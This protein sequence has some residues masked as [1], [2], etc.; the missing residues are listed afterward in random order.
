MDLAGF[1]YEI[2]PSNF[3][4]KTDPS[5]SLE[6]QSI[7]LAYGKAKDVFDNTQGDRCIIGADTLVILDNEQLGKPIS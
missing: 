6:E 5:L 7:N 3:E 2:I 4:E 1:E